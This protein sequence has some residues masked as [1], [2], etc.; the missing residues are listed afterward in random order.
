MIEK[1]ENNMKRLVV[2]TG[3]GIEAIRLEVEAE[4]YPF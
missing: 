2:F 3:A 1:G 4:E